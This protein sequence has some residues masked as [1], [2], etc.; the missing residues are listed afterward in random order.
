VLTEITQGQQDFS[1]ASLFCSSS[2]TVRAAV[3]LKV[4]QLLVAPVVVYPQIWVF[5]HPASA[6]GAIGPLVN[7]SLRQKN[8][9]DRGS[10][11]G[12]EA[13]FHW[14][15]AG[16]SRAPRPYLRSLSFFVIA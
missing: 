1:C 6:M 14:K 3:Q 4:E 5:G 8:H 16:N 7:I 15:I 12:G 9:F 13:E 10:E 11:N 2:R